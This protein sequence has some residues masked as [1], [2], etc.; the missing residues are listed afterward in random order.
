MSNIKLNSQKT[1]QNSPTKLTLRS[2]TFSKLLWPE[3]SNRTDHEID[4]AHQSLRRL[5]LTDPYDEEE[6]THLRSTTW[7]ILLGALDCKAEY[8]FDLVSRP[9]SAWY[10][11]ITNDTFRTLATDSSF[12]TRVS[13][14]MLV[15][16]LEAFVSRSHDMSQDGGTG[17]SQYDFTYV[18]GMNVLAAPFLYTLPSELEAFFCFTRFIEFHCPLYV[19]PTLEG[20]HSALQLLDECLEIVDPELFHYLSTKNLRAE[21]Y[22]FPSVLT[23]CA[24]TEPLDQVL[25]LWDY[26]LAFGVGLNVLCVISQLYMMRERVL[27]HPS[28]M[29]ILRKFPT[30][31][32]RQV[33]LL[34]NVFIRDLPLHLYEK[35]VRHPFETVN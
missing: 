8:Y 27:A 9:P 34:T 26:L 31:E 10:K 6:A 29:A 12:Q 16:L 28:P 3:N 35:L 17:E 19:Q 23:L 5:I 20:V 13:D 18:Q 24:C 2:K 7:K 4:Q 33:I 32:A 21:I 14:Q 25:Q 11:K 30:L 22:A 1:T 15:R